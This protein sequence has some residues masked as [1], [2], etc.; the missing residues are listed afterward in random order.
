MYWNYAQI[1]KW[2]TRKQHQLST[3]EKTFDERTEICYKLLMRRIF[4]E[5]KKLM[6]KDCKHVK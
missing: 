6:P 3:D 5:I 4:R 2:K 1:V